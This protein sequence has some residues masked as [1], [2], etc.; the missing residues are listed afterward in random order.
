VPAI[1]LMLDGVSADT[2]ARHPGRFPHL[3]ALAAR[4]A[5]VDRLAAEVPGT[6]LPGRASILTGVGSAESGVYGNSLWDGEAFRYAT[7]DDVRVPTIAARALAAGRTVASI[8]MGMVRPRDATL[9]AHPWWVTSFVRRGRDA[10]PTPAERGWRQVADRGVDAEVA[11]AAAALG[12]PGSFDA[13]GDDAERAMAGFLGDRRVAEWVAA[14]ALRATPP[15]LILAE[16]LMTDTVQHRAGHDTPL[17]LW[18]MSTADAYV[19]DILTRLRAAGR[20]EAFDVLVLSDH[21]HGP[22]DRALRP[23]VLLPA[24]RCHSEGGILHVAPRDDHEADHV[25]GV[26]TDHGCVPYPTDHLPDDRRGALLAFLAPDGVAFEHDPP[27]PTEGV[28]APRATS[29][30]GARPGHP[31]DDRIL[32]AAGPNVQPGRHA[33]AH[34]RALMTS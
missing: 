34:A 18:S 31:A 29:S 20:E 4:G 11:E 9:F 8:G 22:I 23:D 25:A 27:A 15:D 14:V 26:L 6:S 1:V 32:I 17:S 28:T 3:T 12:I 7:P 24:V 5:R 2:F 21:G 30:H 33:A 13:L 19:G 10:E 16:F